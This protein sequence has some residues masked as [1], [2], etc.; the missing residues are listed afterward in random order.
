MLE[1]QQS[2]L[3]ILIFL[4]IAFIFLSLLRMRK[5]TGLIQRNRYLQLW[6][7]LL[8]LMIVFII[9]K[10]MSDVGIFFSAL[11]THEGFM[12][13]VSG[14]EFLCGASCVYLV[15]WLYHLTLE[16]IL[17]TNVS[18]GY[19]ENILKS[20][21]D[22][23]VVVNPDGYIQTVNQALCEL[24]GYEVEELSGQALEKILG[25]SVDFD[26]LKSTNLTEKIRAELQGSFEKTYLSK[27]GKQI[28]VRFSG[29][30]LYDQA[31]SFQGFVCVAQ[32]ITQQKQAKEALQQYRKHLE[33]RSA[34]LETA[35]KKLQREFIECKRT[36]AEWQ[37]A[38]EAAEAANLAK[39]QF[40]A[41]LQQAKEAAEAA[42]LAKSQFLA[43]TSHELRTPLNGIIGFSQLLKED[44]QE[45]GYTDFIPDL[46]AIHSSGKHLLSL[47][48]D[49]LDISKI[50]AG[51]VDLYLETFDLPKLIDEVVT[52]TQPLVEKNGNA[53]IVDCSKSAGTIHADLCKVRQVLLNL[54]SN[55]AK[56]TKQGTITLEVSREEN[57]ELTKSNE[58]FH[59]S[60]ILF[61][62]TDTG[63]GMT[64]KQLQQIFKAFT[65]A[66]ASTTRKYGGTGLGLTIS[67][68][69]CQIMGG[70][71]E[72]FSQLGE[73]S[74]FTVRLPSQV[75]GGKT[76]STLTAEAS[77]SETLQQ[78][79]EKVVNSPQGSSFQGQQPRCLKPAVSQTICWW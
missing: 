31:G 24:L 14:I 17:S 27:D 65:Q 7:I 37:K 62:V 30:T 49:I 68:H 39:N 11:D 69:F 63:I 51:E 44:A 47:I 35:N 16:E 13:L 73:G 25:L 32:D 10:L 76:K 60:F 61:R 3:Y 77:T 23:L 19:V 20:M 66:D 46:E 50:E 54:L 71:I 33:E 55:A 18:K 26:R 9:G 79:K 34:E 57:S 15:V 72:V 53:L 38:K 78:V 22:T 21:L 59:S 5:M 43:N 6:R 36:E 56:F 70:E 74:T 4:G 40:L 28:P 64:Q 12:P 41:K 1:F 45:L 52:T 29:S 42:N 8:F 2:A 58:E 75:V 67:R 48:N